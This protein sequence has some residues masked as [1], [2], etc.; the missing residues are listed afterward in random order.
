ME[1]TGTHSSATQTMPAPAYNT[2]RTLP[3]SGPDYDTDTHF[4]GDIGT[5]VVLDTTGAQ[6]RTFFLSS[7]C[8]G[9]SS[10][11]TTSEM[12]RNSD[13]RTGVIKDI[14]ELAAAEIT[15]AHSLAGT[16]SSFDHLLDLMNTTKDLG[17]QHKLLWNSSFRI[18][19]TR[20]GGGHRPGVGSALGVSAPPKSITELFMVRNRRTG[21]A[22]EMPNAPDG[23]SDK[24]YLNFWSMHPK[25]ASV[26]HPNY[27]LLG[28]LYPMIS[29][30]M[31]G[32]VSGT[33]SS[34]DLHDVAA[35]SHYPVA[36]DFA[37]H[38]FR[39]SMAG[40]TALGDP[41]DREWDIH[42]APTDVRAVAVPRTDRFQANCGIE[43]DLV[44][45]LQHVR[46]N[47]ADHGLDKAGFASKTWLDFMP[48]VGELTA[49]GDHELVLVL[50]TGKY[51]MK[52]VDDTVPDGY[53]P[54]VAGCHAVAHLSI[55]RPANK[56][57]S[58]GGGSGKH[59][60]ES[61][62]TYNILG[63]T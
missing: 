42:I 45:E 37:D 30:S 11:A 35:T 48:S 24:P 58:S 36:G 34:D 26:P 46:D 18:L 43:I 28:H 51:G 27:A 17:M 44:S 62:E 39:A 29:D 14:F 60:G 8:L 5:S 55:N 49:P 4:L 7:L 50:Y 47:A 9:F 12:L 56:T 10:I 20:P 15:E 53:L 23:P 32:G 31:G 52:M 22:V 41:F 2:G 3:A 38:K 13:H 61:L 59:H 40:D 57:P 54:P 33:A 25:A 6:S 21:A 1:H 63:H 16:P 19:H